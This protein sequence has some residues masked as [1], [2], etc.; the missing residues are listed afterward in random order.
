MRNFTITN[1][2]TLIAVSAIFTIMAAPAANAAKSSKE[3]GIGIGAG[4]IIGAFAGGPVGF[5]LGAGLGAK[6][7]DTLH[8]K[9]EN[10]DELQV[11]LRDSRSDVDTLEQ[12]VDQ[13]SDEVRKL[14]RVARPELLALLQAGIDMDLLFRTDEFA[15]T[16]A[17]GS[18]LAEMAATLAGMPE[19]QVQ[20]DGF[21]DERGDADY[22]LAL[23]ERRVDFVRSL[24]VDAGV[25][26][27]RIRTS[28]HGESIAQDTN[29]DSYAL[30]RRVSV[31][32]YIDATQS[33][34]SNPN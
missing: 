27:Q 30:E 8:K 1:F 28:A 18:R 19:V 31:K 17:T 33:L 5:V 11:S 23:S 4:A 7:G 16:D 14:Q 22:N 3:E 26:P 9:D 13:L 34:A 21:A 15:L 29:V 25:H 24:L 10:I 32:L 6:I 20:L 2:K 12:G